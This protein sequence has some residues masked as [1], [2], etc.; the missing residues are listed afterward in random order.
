LHCFGHNDAGQV[1]RGTI[2]GTDSTYAPVLGQLQSRLVATGSVNT[3]AVDLRGELYC[4]GS[5]YGPTFEHMEERTAGVPIHLIGAPAFSTLTVGVANICGLDASGTAWCWSRVPERVDTPLRF[6]SLSA[7]DRATCGA[8]A[9]GDLHCWG[10]FHPLTVS[11]RLP[12]AN[13]GIHR[14]ARGEQF[15]DIA[16][17]WEYACGIT[18]DGRLLC[19]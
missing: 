14:V 4:W 7:G 8:E 16:T 15:R 11:D 6:A 3:C 2:T 12:P 19:W 18:L 10:K 9:G 1:G 5:R 13:T 17:G